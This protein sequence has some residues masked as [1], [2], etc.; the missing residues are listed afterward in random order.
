MSRPSTSAN[1][2]RRSSSILTIAFVRY[3][4]NEKHEGTVQGGVEGSHNA[5]YLPEDAL[6]RYFTEECIQ[7]IQN[8]L[9]PQRTTSD[10]AQMYDPAQIRRKYPRVLATL[11]YIERGELLNEFLSNSLL[12]DKHLPFFDAARFPGSN[13]DFQNFF[14]AQWKFFILP[15]KYQP[16]VNY[17]PSQIL[18]FKSVGRLGG[19]NGGKAYLIEVHPHHN[20]LVSASSRIDPNETDASSTVR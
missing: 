14:D 8:Q 16:I 7:H 12:D 4:E 2:R 19:G 15:L 20:Q 10:I 6:L 17:Q 9:Y 1:H 13:E 18:P 5:D 3:F 11:L